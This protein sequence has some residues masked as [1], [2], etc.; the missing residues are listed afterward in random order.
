M[1]EKKRLIAEFE[2]QSFTQ[3]IFPHAD[4]D[5]A[6]YLDKAQKTFVNIINTIRKY[7]KCLVIAY[8]IDEVKAHFKDENNLEF[9]QYIT[10]D[11]WARDCSAL[12]LEQNDGTVLLDFIFNGWGN[13]FDAKKDNAMTH[14]IA[15]KYLTCKLKNIDFILEGGAVE[16]N[17]RGT[18]LT[19]SVCMLN[20]NRNPQFNAIQI[21]QKLKAFFHAEHILYLNHGYLAGDD[22]DSHID[23]LARFID[24]KTIMYVKCDNINDEHYH[25]LKLMEEELQM[26]AKEQ[27]LELISLPMC[28]ALYFE[29]ERLPATYAN[30]LFVNGAVL[31]PLYGVSQDKEALQIF[32]NTFK[33]RD[34]I[35]IDCSVL[36]RQHGSLHCVTMN[37][38]ANVNI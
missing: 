4:T 20:K 6:E 27:D 11:T 3:I 26:T 21:T 12:S 2:A 23:T 10:D 38:P 36:V 19:T 24:E 34:V 8:D 31:V 17:G 33:N 1:K 15:H 29:A 25:E 28:D 18:I 35:G 14:N 16:S 13:K 37:F 9:V 22:T 5:W 30:F 32:R 7:Q